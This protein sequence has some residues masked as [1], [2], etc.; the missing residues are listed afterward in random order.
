MSRG[1]STNIG[2]RFERA[3]FELMVGHGF[4]HLEDPKSWRR[5]LHEK[6]S[7][8]QVPDFMFEYK[9]IQFWV[10]CI[11]RSSFTGS[12]LNLYFKEECLSREKAYAEL[13][14]PL[15]IAVGVGGTPEM[16]DVFLFDYYVRFNMNSMS[17][18]HVGRVTTHFRGDFI[19]HILRKNFEK[20]N[21]L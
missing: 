3:F 5:K 2:L 10:D 1:V 8:E 13:S 19:E 18:D 7:D 11:Y 9:G 21:L 16:P 12:R 20:K 17:R 14:D 4:I 6:I 15:F